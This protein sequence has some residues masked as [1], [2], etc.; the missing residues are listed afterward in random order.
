MPRATPEWQGRTDDTPAPPRVKLRV[1]EAYQGRCHWSGRKIMP[2]DEWDVDHVMALI[3]G[4]KNVESNLAPILRGK[5]HKEKTALDVAIKA[6]TARMRQK[7]LG[8]FP[9][10]RAK[11]RSRGFDQ[12]RFT[13]RGE[14]MPAGQNSEG[15]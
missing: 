1:L 4:G 12:T 15:D 6:K 7:H 5:P 10:S 14:I 8:V 11:L 3:N 9:A 2:G 13:R